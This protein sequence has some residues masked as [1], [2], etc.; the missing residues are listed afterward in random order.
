MRLLGIDEADALIGDSLL[1]LLRQVRSGYANRPEGFPHSLALIGL[2]DI[3]DY[4]IFS[5]DSGDYLI[6]G[7]AFNISNFTLEEV[8]ALYHQHTEATGQVFEEEAVQFIHEQT[9]GQPWLVNAIAK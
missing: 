6:G 9:G 1:S 7:S 3:Q 8:R 2:R 4:R 5:D